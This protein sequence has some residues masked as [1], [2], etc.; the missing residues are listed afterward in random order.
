MGL[1]LLQVFLTA[2]HFVLEF[3]I[4]FAIVSWFIPRRVGLKG[5]F[6]AHLVILILMVVLFGLL[7]VLG[8]D[9]EGGE[10]VFASFIFAFLINIV[11]LP[12]TLTAFVF[13]RRARK[14]VE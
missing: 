11:L 9:Y 2:L 13:H 8:G 5:V 3:T 14:S 4:A 10:Q 6:I 1:F 7:I 12:V